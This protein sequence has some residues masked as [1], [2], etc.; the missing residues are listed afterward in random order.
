MVARSEPPASKPGGRPPPET[1]PQG[2]VE[3]AVKL[4]RAWELALF[5]PDVKV[6]QTPSDVLY[7]E[8][9][10]RLLHY[11]RPSTV[12]EKNRPPILCVY[13]LVNKAYIMDLQP[14]LSVIE[15][16][17][18]RGLD[19]YL[20]DWGTPNALD[21]DLRIHDYVNGYVDAAVRATQREAGVDQI[22]MLGYCMGGAFAAMYAARHPENLRTLTLMA[23]PLDFDT[24]SSFLNVW[25][26]APGFDAWKVARSYGLIPPDFFNSA[27]AMLDPLRTNYLK[28][29]TLLERLDDPAFVEN[30]LRMELWNM[31]G[32]PMAGPTY[33][34]FID[35]G[36]Q[37]NLLVKGEWTLDGD[38][39]A[40]DLRRITMPVATIVGLK[41]NLVPPE[42]TE[43]V[44]AHIGSHEIRKFENPSGHIGLSTSR[45]AHE[46]LWP[47]FA[48]WIHEHNL[49]SGPPPAE[50]AS[51]P[52]RR[53]K[54]AAHTRPPRRTP[55]K[56]RG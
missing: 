32:I 20:I 21:Q 18:A 10:M 31:D 25:A 13:A 34:E 9:R 15:D 7:S 41:D 17:L 45:R 8:G 2:F 14:G 11:R 33:A 23:A 36:Y 56:T 30:F 29:Q 48:A 51:P 37:R 1:L 46:D 39:Q 50:R 6:G 53:R 43:G 12:T 38:D 42:S 4:R 3:F 16:L 19:V 22:H 47:H 54:A 40:I 24:R 35:K 5:P 44:L 28:F 27:F 52:R 49:P 26:K 55:R